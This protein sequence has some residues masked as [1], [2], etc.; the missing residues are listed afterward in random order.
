MDRDY[1]DSLVALMEKSREKLKEVSERFLSDTFFVPVIGAEIEFF[2]ADAD[3]EQIKEVCV[4]EK[5]DIWDVK[6]EEGKDQWEI[7]VT[8]KSN[9]LTIADAI[10]KIRELFE[11]ADFS[12]VPIGEK[13]GNSMQIHISL[14]DKEL[15]NIFEKN[16]DEESEYMHYAIGGLLK[17][18]PECMNVYAPYEQCYERLKK[19]RNAPS[20]ISWG[21]N[22][23]TVAL[24]L[25]ATTMQNFNRRIEHRVASADADPYMVISSILQ[26][27]AKGILNKTMPE[28]DK[29]YGDASLEMYALPKLVEGNC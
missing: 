29:I 13:F 14:L 22:N 25:P 12:A 27:V 8:H 17:A 11:E 1:V 5:I 15:K 2:L 23:R 10:A 4:R 9:P 26:G 3:V 16:G 6:K 7:S 24:R 20:T 21:G 28:S 19:D 18:M